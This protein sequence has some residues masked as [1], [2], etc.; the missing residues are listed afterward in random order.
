MMRSKR[1]VM[2]FHRAAVPSSFAMS[3]HAC[4]KPV[5]FGVLPGCITCF[6]IL[7]LTTS[8]KKKAIEEKFGQ[9]ADKIVEMRFKKFFTF[10]CK[11][12]LMY[13]SQ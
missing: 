7:V 8:A 4:P 11:V 9:K 1:G 5:Y 12:N 6:C 2:P 3:E 13:H 10:V